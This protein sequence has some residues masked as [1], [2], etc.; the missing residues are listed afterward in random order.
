MKSILWIL[1]GVFLLHR[2]YNTLPIGNLT[3]SLGVSNSFYATSALI[4]AAALFFF[5]MGWRGLTT[6]FSAPDNGSSSTAISDRE[7]AST[8]ARKDETESSSDFDVDGA[9]ERYMQNRSAEPE[10]TSAGPAPQPSQ[11]PRQASFGRK[12]T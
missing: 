9:F 10:A 11:P 2:A 8:D 6:M 4:T 7:L 12:S 3:G 5:Y 1:G